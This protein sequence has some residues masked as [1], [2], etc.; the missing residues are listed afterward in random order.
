MISNKIDRLSLKH[1][2]A[3]ATTGPTQ[4]TTTKTLTNL[5][6]GAWATSHLYVQIK[7]ADGAIPPCSVRPSAF[8]T[9]AD[10][11]FR[12]TALP[13]GP[14]LLGIL[15]G[16]SVRCPDHRKLL[17]CLLLPLQNQTALTFF[18]DSPHFIT[19]VSFYILVVHGLPFRSST[20][21]KM[22]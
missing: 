13:K 22:A 9:A 11:L 20:P 3:Q 6:V 1:R 17:L 7:V 18:C 16:S 15:F 10:G 12:W 14:T 19:F 5:F 2:I 21:L 8:A 4:P